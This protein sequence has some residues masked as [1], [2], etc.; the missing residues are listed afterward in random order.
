M[1]CCLE[2]YIV[3]LCLLAHSQLKQDANILSS[4]HTGPSE[5]YI[6]FVNSYHML[7]QS[8]DFF[9]TSFEFSNCLGLSKYRN[10]GRS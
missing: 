2:T 5:A 7:V 10:I 8:F 9:C 4:M 3:S 1:R 6:Y